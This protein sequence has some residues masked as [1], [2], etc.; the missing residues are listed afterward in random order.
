[1]EARKSRLGPPR[2]GID[3]FCPLSWGG[4]GLGAMQALQWGPVSQPAP[5]L[6][7][8]GGNWARRAPKLFGTETF[9]FNEG[10]RARQ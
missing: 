7:H 6:A 8:S 2:L 9:A 3:R 5:A 4:Q 10:G 1:V